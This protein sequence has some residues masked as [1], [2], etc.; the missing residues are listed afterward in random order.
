M[1]KPMRNRIHA[2]ALLLAAILLATGCSSKG[3]SSAAPAAGSYN[4]SYAEAPMEA[5]L[6]EEAG[7]FD[8]AAKY[9]EAMEMESSDAGASETQAVLPA[10]R[11]LIRTVDMDVETDTFEQLLASI[12]GRITA[13]GGYVEQS[14]T[15]GQGINSYN[16]PIPRFAYLVA[17]IPSD[18]LDSFISSVEGSGNVTSKSVNTRDV[19][20]QYSDI[21][22]RKKTLSVEQDRIWALLEKADSLEAVIALEERLSEIRYELE[23]M[24]SQLRL[25]DN[26]VDYST[27]T[28]RISEVTAYT[29]VTPETV[30]ERIEKGFSRSLDNVKDAA[31]NLFVALVSSSPIWVPLLLLLLLIL[32]LLKHRRKKRAQRA[33]AENGSE[34]GSGPLPQKEKRSLREHF[35]RRKDQ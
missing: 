25:Y 6:T 17:R 15:S 28:L 18:K 20:L 7:V 3:S 2:P 8:D 10:G 34:T 22:S 16:H 24:E 21:E 32:A 14:D 29:P 35:R 31:V 19:T 4:S 13:L 33:E 9:E 5:M 26:Q 27:V 1:K 23:S 30:G 11:K 12:Q